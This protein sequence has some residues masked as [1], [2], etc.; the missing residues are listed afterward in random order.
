MSSLLTGVRGGR[1]WLGFRVWATVVQCVS[2]SQGSSCPTNKHCFFRLINLLLKLSNPNPEGGL[3]VSL[4]CGV[5]RVTC[6]TDPA[7]T[8]VVPQLVCHW[9]SIAP[10]WLQG[11][12]ASAMGSRWGRLFLFLWGGQG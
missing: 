6:A 11:H 9:E 3:P 5:L 8:G 10:W 7:C 1:A 2:L 4:C 12:S